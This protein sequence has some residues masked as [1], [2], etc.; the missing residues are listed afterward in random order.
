[1]RMGCF[2]DFAVV[3][4]DPVAVGTVA[5]SR[6]GR[7][8]DVAAAVG[9]LEDMPLGKGWLSSFAVVEPD[10]EE[11]HPRTSRQT[12]VLNRVGVLAYKYGNYWRDNYRMGCTDWVAGP[13]SRH[14][15]YSAPVVLDSTD[16]Q[17]G[18]VAPCL[19]WAP[20]VEVALQVAPWVLLRRCSF[21]LA[22]LTRE[23]RGSESV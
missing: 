23:Y 11:H 18:Q 19:Q 20:K 14:T 8:A 15:A 17:V 3:G 6:P 16:E 7:I 2:Q 21:A 1:M 5:G 10:M 12:V 22:E 13:G 4:E 9:S